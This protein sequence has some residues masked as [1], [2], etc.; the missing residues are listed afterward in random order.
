MYQVNKK[1]ITYLSEFHIY[2]IYVPWVYYAHTKY[3]LIA[4]D[5]GQVNPHNSVLGN[6]FIGY[7]LSYS[8]YH[9]HLSIF[10][11]LGSL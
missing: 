11:P 10:S 6:E 9:L 1:I 7:F 8:N 4:M 3:N 5:G 2:M